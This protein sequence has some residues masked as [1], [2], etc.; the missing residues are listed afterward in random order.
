MAQIIEVPG[1]GRVEFPDG[2]D[3]AQIVAAIKKI[4]TPQ[5]TMGRIANAATEYN[6][7][8]GNLETAA[9]L[10]SGAAGA[11]AG[12]FAGIGQG[13][14]NIVSPGMPA[15]DRVRQVQDAM[16]YQPRT[17]MGRGT[18]E[19]AS[20]IPEK[21]AEGADYVGGV[22]A[23]ATGSPA[24]GAGVNT[25]LQMAPSL[26]AKGVRAPLQR[27]L[28]NAET[29]AADTRSMNS[30]KDTTIND[31]REL[32]YVFPPSEVQGSFLGNRLEGVG[33]KAALAQEV[34]RRNQQV[35]NAIGRR[36]AGLQANEPISV[37]T[38]KAAR[39]RLAAPYREVTQLSPTAA[40][41]LEKVQAAR[42]EARDYW[43]EYGRTGVVETKKKAKAFEQE[44]KLQ[45]NIIDLEAARLRVP[46]LLDR[47]K[48]ARQALA[49]N[50]DVESA[51]NK[52]S[53]D[54]DARIWGRMY[55]KDKPLTGDLRSAG[56]TAEAM[57]RFT[58]DAA[59]VPTPGVSKLEAAGATLFGLGGHAALGPMGWGLAAAPLLAPG[60]ARSL[61]LSP[62]MQQPR[63][64][65]P[66]LGLQ[67]LASA[68]NNPSL[69]SLLPA[70]GLQNEH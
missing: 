13:I 56:A 60:P 8:V 35:S 44:A 34:N 41:A 54:L 51:L 6:P 5:T 38:L 70:L 26:V 63:T 47:V 59:A 37:D 1:Q 69:L 16:T 57:G 20:F 40:T 52:G 62:L 27:A 14:K 28:T 42:L 31:A 36:E 19:V 33:G 55:D 66:G 61:A 12:G 17:A 49:K 18:T 68:T 4:S 53:G 9:A 67:G 43:N 10:V 58:K 64:Y 3:D 29:R 21:L 32:G 48:Q 24:V 50:Y 2:M 11:V 7:V 30:V 15:G 22:T 45:E 46:G 25:A 23:E 65:G 39:E